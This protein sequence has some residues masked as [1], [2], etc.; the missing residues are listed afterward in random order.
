M[1]F[2]PTC[3]MSIII[4]NQLIKK[5]V[6]PRESMY[7]IRIIDSPYNYIM[8]ILSLAGWPHFGCYFQKNLNENVKNDIQVVEDVIFDISFKKF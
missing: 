3:K 5:A 8:I 2:G 7:S 1:K 6:M 4:R